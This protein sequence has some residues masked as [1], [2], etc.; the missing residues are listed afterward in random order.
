MLVLDSSECIYGMTAD[1]FA[2]NR[3][4][5]S[6]PLTILGVAGMA[7]LALTGCDRGASEFPS[8]PITIV[9]PW[10]A[11]GGTDGLAR[12][13]AKETTDVLGV[14]VNVLNKTGGQGTIGHAYGM[15]ARPD[16]YTV[17]MVTFELCTYKALGR[18]HVDASGFTPLM[19]LNED[20]AALTVN[21]DSPYATLDDFIAAAKANPGKIAVG[22]SGP[23]VVWHLAAIQFEQKAG[24]ELAHVPFD[25]AA[26]AV[27]QLLGKHIDAV[28]V[29]PAEVLQHVEVGRLRT[30]AVMTTERDPSIP[31]VPTFRELGVDVLGAGWRGLAVPKTTPPHIVDRL[32]KGFKAAYDRPTF[33]EA[34]RKAQLNLK[35]LDREA[36]TATLADREASA[37]AAVASVARSDT[38]VG[39]YL[40]GPGLVPAIAGAGFVLLMVVLAVTELRGRA[41]SATEG[42][43]ADGTRRAVVWAV[44]GLAAYWA[45]MHVLGYVG[46]TLA[47]FAFLQAVVMAER[48]PVRIVISSV[49]VTAAVYVA[50][51][52][53]LHVPLPTP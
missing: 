46:P 6:F 21:A 39:Q 3:P 53:I 18:G 37:G 12:A 20:P 24:I 1:E 49:A 38:S 47:F 29:S 2:G 44:V 32:I 7:V 52:T 51:G 8:K 41:A 31:D 50:F 30:L 27:V 42:S 19:Q 28:P 40:K 4:P 16:G 15:S 45:A 48:R 14:S 26:P 9:V 13:L 36:F 17:T 22:N 10:K 34:A 33:K 11:G 35:Y 25:G 43:C 23:G 5:R